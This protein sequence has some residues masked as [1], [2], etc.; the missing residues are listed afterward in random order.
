VLVSITFLSVLTSWQL[1]RS[2]SGNRVAT[3]QAIAD[4]A[5]FAARQFSD[6]AWG[7]L[8]SFRLRTATPAT[9]AGVMGTGG[10]GPLPD[11]TWP[12]IGHAALRSLQLLPPSLVD[13]GWR[14]FVDPTGSDT[15]VALTLVDR[16]QRRIFQSRPAFL[17]SPTGTMDTRDRPGGFLASAT[18]HPGLVAHLRTR[19]NAA[20]RA[21]IH[22]QLPFLQLGPGVHVPVDVLI[23]L[24]SLLLGAAAWMHL[25]RERSL[26]RARRDFVASVSHELRTPLA[27]I[28]M[29]AETLYLGRERNPEE[30]ARWLDVM[31]RES[32][33]LGDLVENILL[34]SH[35][36]ADKARLEVERTDLGELVEEVVESCLPSAARREVR[37]I[38]DAPS[39]IFGVVDPRALRQVI[40]NLVDNAI[41]YGPRG[42]V[43]S[44]ELERDGRNARITV[45]DQGPGI[46]AGDRHLVWNPFVRLGREPGTTG[47][48]GIGLS[49]VRGLVEQHGGR[50]AIED[51]PGGGARF[52]VLLPLADAAASPQRHTLEAPRSG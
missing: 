17:A 28:R 15:I 3:E 31:G 44:V 23:P 41:K 37:L 40:V 45:S 50:V 35:L 2:L 33:R 21:T 26:V 27:Q 12:V 48:S 5:S 38:A 20:Q 13:P 52:V 47:G 32:R 49:V 24:L 46:G 39:R 51:A 4:Y 42:Q 9:L 19:L 7:E 18:L 14:W 34:F 22:L 30:R 36:D 29:F 10:P 16:D 6:R 25:T 1:R 11:S 43:V 8:A